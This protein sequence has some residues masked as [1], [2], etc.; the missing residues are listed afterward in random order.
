LYRRF[1]GAK[2]HF[3]EKEIEFF[4]NVD[5]VSHVALVATAEEGNRTV[6]FGGGRYVI[7][8]PGKSLLQ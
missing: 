5:F 8:H 7:V 3:S 4:V 1:F 2:R 6:I